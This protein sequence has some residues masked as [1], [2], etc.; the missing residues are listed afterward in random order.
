MVRLSSL[1]KPFLVALLPWLTTRRRTRKNAVNLPNTDLCNCSCA[2]FLHCSYPV[3]VP[4]HC[5]FTVPTL[6]LFLC[7]IPSLFL[8]PTLSMFLCTVP[9][10]FLCTVPVHCSFTVQLCLHFLDSPR[11]HCIKT[12]VLQLTRLEFKQFLFLL[13]LKELET[14]FYSLKL[15]FTA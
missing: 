5:S 11:G 2:L 8:V 12:H 3:T 7:S 1:S 9:S 15:C 6:S 14:V 4:V 10:L 13:P